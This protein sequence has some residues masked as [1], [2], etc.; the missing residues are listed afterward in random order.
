MGSAMAKANDSIDELFSRVAEI[1]E[2]AR[3]TVARTINTA[4]VQAYW[5]VGR[6]IVEVEQS[7]DN[8]AR[9][10]DTILNRLSKR[11]TGQFG[12]GFSVTNLKQIRRFFF[13]FPTGSTIG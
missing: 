12:P 1:L 2:Q 9:Y 5:Q 3:G 4:M 13:V 7:G 8:R 10:G 11:L 6:E